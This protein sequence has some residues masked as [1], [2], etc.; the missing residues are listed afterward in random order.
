MLW[1]CLDFPALGREA[2]D[3][4]AA[5]AILGT[6]GSHRWLIADVCS[7]RRT[8]P[9]GTSLATARSYLPELVT[10]PRNPSAERAELEARAHALYRFGSPVVVGITEIAEPCW[11]PRWQVFVEIGASLSLFGGL[12]ALREAVRLALIELGIEARCGIAPSRSAAGLLAASSEATPCLSPGG[13][14]ERLAPLPLAALPWPVAQREALASVG[15]R[16]LGDLL[17]LP[18]AHLL[19]RFGAAAVHGLEALLGERAEPFV[20]ITPPPVFAI[21]QELHGE[22]DNV[23]TLLFP[24]KRMAQRF[25][26]YLDARAV[27]ALQVTLTCTHDL[28]APTVIPLELLSPS[29]DAARWLEVIRERLYRSPPDRAVRE[30]HWQ[31][32]AFLP[33]TGAQGALFDAHRLSR[34]RQAMLEKLLARYGEQGLWRPALADDHRPERAFARSPLSAPDRPLERL[35]TRA[36]RPL[37]LLRKPLA[38]PAQTVETLPERIETGWWDASPARRDY[39]RLPLGTRAAWVYRDLDSGEWH[40]HGL[41]G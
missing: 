2:L 41:W 15:L 27:T 19:Q 6:H 39:H 4:D 20:A 28:G 1:L 13:L 16:R 18:R 33:R 38:I 24:L 25:A 3:A 32:E 30:L 31:A 12:A 11:V 5:T 37:W 23:E 40:L 36:P 8:L 29:H 17:A 10:R 34:E 7:G 14:P 35:R 22:V 21:R 26:A 9:A